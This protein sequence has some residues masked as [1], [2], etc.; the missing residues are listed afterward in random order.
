MSDPDHTLLFRGTPRILVRARLKELAARIGEKAAAGRR[1]SCLVTRDAEL[2]RLNRDFLG[3]DY[4][5]DVLSFPAPDNPPPDGF[6]GEVA[7]SYDRAAEQADRFGHPVED[8][9]GI[10]MLHGVLHLLGMNH[11]R[12]RGAMARRERRLRRE[13]GLPAGLIERAR[14]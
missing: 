7:I 8:E 4:P 9:I 13:I 6:L 3:R 10:L 1:F 11:E 2:Q 12:D 5:A 14:T